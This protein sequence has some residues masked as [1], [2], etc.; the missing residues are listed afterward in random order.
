VIDHFTTSPEAY[1]FQVTGV[2]ISGY[3]AKSNY[4]GRSR[5]NEIVGLFFLLDRIDIGVDVLKLEEY[6]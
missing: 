2:I 3:G 5:T 1:L 6:V 4:K